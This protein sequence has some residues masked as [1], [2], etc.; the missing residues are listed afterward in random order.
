M[1]PMKGEIT[2]IYIKE[3]S[4]MGKVLIDGSY[5]HVPLLL[6]LNAKVGDQVLID[7]GIA[8]SKVSDKHSPKP[9]HA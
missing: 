7:A 1:N 6:L 9:Q 3:G 8:V 5:F 4:T 2:E